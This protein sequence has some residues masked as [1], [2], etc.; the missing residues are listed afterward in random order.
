MPD[1]P[2]F[3]NDLHQNPDLLLA[4]Q[5]QNLSDRFLAPQNNGFQKLPDFLLAHHS[6]W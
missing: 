3:G 4:P 2:N 5:L 6:G 1:S